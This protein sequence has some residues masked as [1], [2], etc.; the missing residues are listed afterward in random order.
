MHALWPTKRGWIAL[1]VAV[2]SF[3]IAMTNLSLTAC[4]LSAL[5]W[6]MLPASLIM[7]AF[8]LHGLEL[9]REPSPDG[10]LGRPLALPVTVRNRYRRHRQTVLIGEA[11]PF[12]GPGLTFTPVVGLLPKEERLVRRVVQPRRRGEYELE[13]V[14]LRGGDPA[15][16]FYRQQIYSFPRRIMVYPLQVP[17]YSLPLQLRHR[18]VA[19][20]TGQPIGA[21]GQGQEFFGVRPYRPTD[22]I[23]FIHWKAS[24]RQRRLMVRE[25]EEAAVHQVSVILDSH[26]A[27]LSGSDAES[28]FEYQVQVAASLVGYLGG[29][30]CRL[31]FATG[32]PGAPQCLTG[33]GPALHE[34]VLRTLATITPGDQPL[35]TVLGAAVDRIPPR[36][37]VYCLTLTDPDELQPTFDLLLRQGTE[38]RCLYAAPVTFRGQPGAPQLAERIRHGRGRVAATLVT[39]Q[40]DLA[41]VLA[42]G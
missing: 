37:I 6:A 36:S 34:R 42:H 22:G 13:R 23:R 31:L 40:T 2:A 1:A 28:N 27:H 17:L 21:S 30:Y 16:L 41:Q 14:V 29:L 32:Q 15:G 3:F 18:V 33:T 12:V 9:R 5:L 25:F 8:S 20:A 7:A 4:V 19:S 38:V 26:A 39:P 24:A 11:L 10:M 35:A